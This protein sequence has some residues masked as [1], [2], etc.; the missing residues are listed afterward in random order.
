M[1]D[2]WKATLRGGGFV[3]H[4]VTATP[5]TPAK[6]TLEIDVAAEAAAGD[7]PDHDHRHRAATTTSAVDVTLDVAEQVDSGIQ[8]TADFPSLKGDP[9]TRFTY[10][11]TITNNTPEEQTFTFDPTGPAG[12]DGDGV[13]DRR[14]QGQDGH[15]RRR[16]QRHGAR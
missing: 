9:A 14:G 2:G 6:A 10:N 5:D 11:L 12:L 8:V 15:D 13:A 7:V 1:P 16:R 4:A 3:I